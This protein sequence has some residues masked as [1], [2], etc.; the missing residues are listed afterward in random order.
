MKLSYTCSYK[1]TVQLGFSPVWI[2]YN[3]QL[4]FLFELD[5]LISSDVGD[6]SG[7]FGRWCKVQ[8]LHPRRDRSQEMASGVRQQIHFW[9][10]D[11]ICMHNSCF[12]ELVPLRMIPEKDKENKE[13]WLDTSFKGVPSMGWVVGLAKRQLK[14]GSSRLIRTASACIWQLQQMDSR[15]TALMLFSAQSPKLEWRILLLRCH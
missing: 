7:E 6:I 15:D 9:D 13:N 8:W 2:S 11:L 5:A 4:I 3:S 12:L 14:G 10:F 1:H